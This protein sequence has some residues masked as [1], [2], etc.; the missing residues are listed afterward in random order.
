MR[1]IFFSF[2]LL[3]STVCYAAEETLWDK[4]KFLGL[5]AQPNYMQVFSSLNEEQQLN[6]SRSFKDCFDVLEGVAVK[7]TGS[8]GHADQF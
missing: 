6:F 2:L 3:G 1:N 7:K 5:L 4:T 8:W